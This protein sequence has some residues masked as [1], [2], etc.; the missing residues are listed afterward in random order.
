MSVFSCHLFVYNDFDFFA[1]IFERFSVYWECDD[2]PIF[3]FKMFN[4]CQLLL[5]GV[6]P[7]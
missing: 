7:I 3:C 6:F 5:P 2:F 1:T 4:A